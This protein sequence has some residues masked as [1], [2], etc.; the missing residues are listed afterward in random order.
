MDSGVTFAVA[1]T[2]VFF[3]TVIWLIFHIRRHDRMES[4]EPQQL[5]SNEPKSIDQSDT[6]QRKAS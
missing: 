4:E 6:R 5:T 2:V 1:L 3:G